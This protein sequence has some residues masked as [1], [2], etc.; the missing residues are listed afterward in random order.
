MKK[1]GRSFLRPSESR[2]LL[3]DKVATAVLLPTGL[4]FFQAERFLLAVADGLD[5]AG[6]DSGGGQGIFYRAG[7]L[8]AQ[9]QVVFGRA[10]VVA[11]SFNRKADVRVLV[12]EEHVGLNGSLLI[13][14]NVGLVVVEV[15]V[16]DSAPKEVF[17]RR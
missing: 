13:A 12:E 4:V 16:L 14:T 17:F 11:V 9:R 3:I 15:N 10:A 2:L 5:A 1:Q 8:I 7:A 6:V